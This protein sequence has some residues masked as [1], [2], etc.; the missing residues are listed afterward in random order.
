MTIT[1]HQLTKEAYQNLVYATIRKMESGSQLYLQPYIDPK[2][3]IT[4][5]DGFNLKDDIVLN[6]VLK[7]FGIDPVR[8]G[9]TADGISAE[10]FYINQIRTEVHKAYSNGIAGDL[11]L[12]RDTL[13]GF[14][15]DRA[16]DPR[17]ATIGVT[18]RSPFTFNDEDDVKGAL[19][20]LIPVYEER[21][22][23]K[24]GQNLS[25]SVEKSVL[26][27]LVY[28]SLNNLN[29][30]FVTAFNTGNRAEAWYQLRYNT[31]L[32]IKNSHPPA[33]EQEVRKGLA[34]R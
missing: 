13:N 23:T 1:F 22:T 28:Q 34:A 32:L 2:N 9:L 20:N 7:Q 19:I 33:P 12:L 4:I 15:A 6:A 24:L 21:L 5:G 3:V 30:E 18:R 16:V 11:I 8:P 29:P 27:S 25:S 26:V 31:I 10:K 17:L 14:M